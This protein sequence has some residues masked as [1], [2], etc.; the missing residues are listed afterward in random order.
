MCNHA[1]LLGSIKILQMDREGVEDRVYRLHY[2]SSQKRTDTFSLVSCEPGRAIPQQ[3][4]AS[5]S[6]R[7][8]PG[9]TR[10]PGCSR[11]H[12]AH[13]LTHT[14]SLPCL[15]PCFNTGRCCA[16]RGSCRVPP[17]GRV[18]CQATALP[19]RCGRRR[20]DRRPAAHA[21]AS[22]GPEVAQQDD[23]RAA[24]LIC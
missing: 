12:T 7:P 5:L 21:D 19:G 11:K 9:C 8:R 20:S 16:G 3:R 23:A 17:E 1:A 18:R 10:A 24:Q 15:L 2:N 13:Q 22:G 4:P 6:N 14:G